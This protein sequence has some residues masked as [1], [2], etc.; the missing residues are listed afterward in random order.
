MSELKLQKLMQ[1]NE[2]LKLEEELPRVKVSEASKAYVMLEN[3]NQSKML[4]V[5]LVCMC[6]SSFSL[7]SFVASTPDPLTQPTRPEFAENPFIKK[8][9]GG[10]CV[11]V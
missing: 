3:T 11:V 7:V 8:A 1:L 9:R 2:R 10:K 5:L 6:A 4:R